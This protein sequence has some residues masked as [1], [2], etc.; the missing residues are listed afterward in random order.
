MPMPRSVLLIITGSVASYKA[1]ELVRLLR[2]QDVAVTGIL[3]RGGA[4]F[5]TPL[6]V[7]A[8][9]GTKTYGDL[10]SLTDEIEMGHIQLSRS[11][12]MVLVAPA[13]ADILAKMAAGIA[14]DLATTALLA[15]NKPVIVAPAMNHKMWNHAAT[16]RNITQ[17]KAD[18]VAVIEPTEGDMAC[19]EFGVGRMA[20][21]VDIVK[22]LAT[23]ATLAAC[24][25]R[26]G[27][28]PESRARGAVPA[29]TGMTKLSGL[30]LAGKHAIVTSGPTV[31][32]ID[33]VRYLGN[34]SS[35]KQGHAIAAALVAAGARVTLVSGSVTLATPEG[36]TA[37]HTKNA[38]RMLAAVEGALPGDIFVA[39][40]AVADW[41]L[42]E[43]SLQKL[44]K[45]SGANKLTLE[46]VP[47]VDILATIA[48]A[49]NRPELVIGFA[50]ETEKLLEHAREKRKAKGCDWL[51]ANEV[52]DGA[53]F[54][55][56][57]NSV[58][59][60]TNTGEQSW[61][62][63]SKQA[64]ADKLVEEIAAHFAPAQ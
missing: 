28:N 1:L 23:D 34:H 58:T 16:Q 20:E 60:I 52:K 55:A 45:K 62:R 50:A 46:L 53:V 9:T 22:F 54:G 59:L 48:R 6:A 49:Q 5:I 3:T 11:A 31:E 47:T 2:A 35:G 36:V 10:F 29:F 51:L 13:S 26:E 64:V 18:G 30:P 12:D 17:L 42:A 14:D 40:A 61:P 15:T 24:H 43:P 19:G 33:P 27:G 21:P 39:A 7:S 57:E 4:Q 32:A 41:R 56:D 44:K 8:L 25:T 63:M 37:V 38:A